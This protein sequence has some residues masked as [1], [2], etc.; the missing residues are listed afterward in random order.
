ML[1]YVILQLLTNAVTCLKEYMHRH[2]MQQC[3]DFILSQ[4][5]K[6]ELLRTAWCREHPS[7]FRCAAA[8]GHAGLQQ[9]ADRVGCCPCSHAPAESPE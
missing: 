3:S 7:A 9:H 8:H 4:K 5:A 6:L 1:T 2:Q